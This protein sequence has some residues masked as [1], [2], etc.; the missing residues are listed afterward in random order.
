M[1][2]PPDVVAVGE[3]GLAGEVRRVTG[4][5]RRLSEA[6]RLGF[7]RALVPPD[8]GPLPP[9]VRATV[10]PDIRSALRVLR[11]ARG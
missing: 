10:V 6:A 4:V 9:D 8:A 5:G 7:T 11:E 2:L 3:V 1:A